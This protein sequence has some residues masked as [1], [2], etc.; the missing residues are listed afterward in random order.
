MRR[1]MW[2]LH[3]R[4]L[5]PPEKRRPPLPLPLFH[6]ALVVSSRSRA[7]VQLFGHLPSYNV[8]ASSEILLLN[9]CS[10]TKQ[11][12]KE[13]NT[14]MNDIWP[15]LLTALLP[16][17]ALYVGYIHQL[18]LEV[19]VL[20]TTVDDLKKDLESVQ[21]RQDSHSKK[22]D[23]ILKSITDLK[24]EMLKEMGKVVAE[25]SSLASEVKNVE[26]KKKGQ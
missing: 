21:K 5:V 4:R 11:Y 20:K 25:V 12:R 17:I 15:Y 14:L 9:L 26:E 2:P 16:A 23:D 22:Q 8:S 13:M 18:K 10:K 24:V 19:A 7:A 6:L 1:G 3:L